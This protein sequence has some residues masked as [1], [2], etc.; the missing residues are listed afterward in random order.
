M[1]EEFR[2]W[3][4]AQGRAV[5]PKSPLGEAIGY[6]LDQWTALT[7]YL[8]D[9]RLDIANNAAE[10]ALRGVA[11]GRKNWLFAGSDAGGRR[12]AIFYSPIETAKRHGVDPFAYLR[13]VIGGV[14]T[15]P[16]RDI[17]AL[18][19]PRARTA[20]PPPLR[21]QRH[22]VQTTGVWFAGRIP[23][24]SGEANSFSLNGRMWI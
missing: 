19:P 2:T 10:R 21:P 7:R 18:L 17:A 1:L 22:T 4:L 5:P 12:A 9:G 16:A 6:T 20:A 14:S 3:L 24:A 13:D 15:H 11:V 8:D 23:Q